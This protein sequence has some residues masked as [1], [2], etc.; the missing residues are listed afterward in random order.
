MSDNECQ[1]ENST[2]KMSERYLVDLDIEAIFQYQI[3]S[4][5]KLFKAIMQ[6]LVIASKQNTNCDH[7]WK[8]H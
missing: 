8:W 5:R 2:N 7:E 4:I 6:I 1:N 3:I